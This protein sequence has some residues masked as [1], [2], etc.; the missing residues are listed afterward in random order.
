[1][2]SIAMAFGFW[3]VGRFSVTY[4]TLFG[5]TPLASLCRKAD[6]CDKI[7]SRCRYLHSQATKDPYRLRFCA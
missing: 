1:M 2:T 4:R 6:V 5:E 7:P 3:G